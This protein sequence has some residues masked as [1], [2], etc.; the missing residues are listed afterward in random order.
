MKSQLDCVR[1]TDEMLRQKRKR[2]VYND[3]LCAIIRLYCL[4]PAVSMCAS[5]ELTVRLFAL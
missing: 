2:L 5:I 3:R 4:T 1:L